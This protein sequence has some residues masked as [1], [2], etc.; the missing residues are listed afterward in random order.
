M[1]VKSELMSNQLKTVLNRCVFSSVLK[2]V[3]DEA[4]C[5]LLG[6]ELETFRAHDKKRRAPI[7]VHDGCSDNRLDNLSHSGIYP[8][9]HTGA[10]T[11]LLH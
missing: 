2:L 7:T 3:R 4:D 11:V 5:T 1:R 9:A 8:A 6:R 10:Y